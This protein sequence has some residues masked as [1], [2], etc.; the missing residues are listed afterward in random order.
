MGIFDTFLFITPRFCDL[1]KKAVRR[2]GL[3]VNEW[4]A[5][6]EKNIV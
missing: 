6:V 2:I 5:G 4:E 1:F 3:F